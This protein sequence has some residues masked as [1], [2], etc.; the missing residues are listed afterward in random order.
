MSI[1]TVVTRGY[2]SWGGVSSVV[3]KGYSVGAATET[4]ADDGLLGG[5]PG[6][7]YIT[8]YQKMLAAREERVEVR[9]AIDTAEAERK[10]LEARLEQAIQSKAKKQTETQ[11]KLELKLQRLDAEILRLLSVL[12]TLEQLLKAWDEEDAL[13]AIALSSPFI[14]F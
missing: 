8:P 11:R 14:R 13:I 6:Y 10:A 7:S 2:G 5:G 1:S 12:Q 9:A 4:L 3:I